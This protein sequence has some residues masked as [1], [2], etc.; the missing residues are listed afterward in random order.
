MAEEISREYSAE[1]GSS[2]ESRFVI[3]K[4][5]KFLDLLS[6]RGIYRSSCEG[7]YFGVLHSIRIDSR[8]E[9]YCGIKDLLCVRGDQEKADNNNGGFSLSCALNLVREFELRNLVFIVEVINPQTYFKD[10]EF[11]RSERSTRREG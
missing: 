10:V 2:R 1:V 9:V 5:Y 3:G 6:C 4:V 11:I 8:G 7:P